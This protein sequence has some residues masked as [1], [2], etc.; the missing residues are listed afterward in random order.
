MRAR[1]LPSEWREG[2][3]SHPTTIILPFRFSPFRPSKN[4]QPSVDSL[5]EGELNSGRTPVYVATQQLEYRDNVLPIEG[6]SVRHPMNIL[7]GG[8][9][10]GR[11]SCPGGATPRSRETPLLRIVQR[12]KSAARRYQSSYEPQQFVG[13]F[14]S[15]ASFP[16]VFF[17]RISF[18]GSTF[19]SFQCAEG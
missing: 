9:G 8:G 2:T 12:Q 11:V 14:G 7:R 4:N 15:A 10:P 19:A 16:G 3:L 1:G 5:L 13:R 18:Y 6:G 17:L